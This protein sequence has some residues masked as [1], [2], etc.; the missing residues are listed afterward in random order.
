MRWRHP[1]LLWKDPARQWRVRIPCWRR[2]TLSRPPC[3]YN[4]RSLYV[5]MRFA[6]QICT[7]N[8]VALIARRISRAYVSNASSVPNSTFACRWVDRS[9]D[10]F[11][12]RDTLS[13][14]PFFIFFHCLVLF[15]SHAMFFPLLFIKYLFFFFFYIS[16]IFSIVF[17]FAFV[18]LCFHFSPISSLSLLS[19]TLFVNL[20]MRLMTKDLV[21]SS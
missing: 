16:Y 7:R 21:L 14:L 9:D 1:N 5:I 2:V 11:E 4:R 18:L 20:W 19:F 8:I 3:H 15:F 10:H 6:F 17:A 13:R 12:S